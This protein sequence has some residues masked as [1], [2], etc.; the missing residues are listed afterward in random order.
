MSAAGYAVAIR[1][2]SAGA[3]LTGGGNLS[4][5]RTIALGTPSTI[6]TNSA[7]SA[8]GTT[9]T[10]A[11]N[12]S[13]LV[14]TSGAQTIN[15]VKTF[16]AAPVFDVAPSAPDKSFAASKIGDITTDESADN[17]AFA[18]SALTFP[19]LLQRLWRGITGLRA[20]VANK[21]TKTDAETIAGVKTFS[22]EPVLPSKSTAAGDN[23]TKPATEAQVYAAMQSGVPQ[24]VTGSVLIASKVANISSG[25]TAS[26]AAGISATIR[27]DG[28]ARIKLCSAYVNSCHYMSF[29]CNG[30]NIYGYGRTGKC[31]DASVT[32]DLTLNRGDVFCASGSCLCNTNN[33]GIAIYADQSAKYLPLNLLS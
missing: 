16:S 27:L 32:C 20:L 21:V 22:S 14:L 26:V 8:S 5:D 29:Y 18:A 1:E 12:T 3:G 24:L 4:A 10:H 13:G 9:H 11:L 2:V 25:S 19:A 15:G 33:A 6:A 30:V 23:P 28:C 31:G 17:T 7:N